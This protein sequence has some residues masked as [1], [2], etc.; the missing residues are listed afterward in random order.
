M[1]PEAAP[2]KRDKQNP[3][4]ENDSAFSVFTAPAMVLTGQ[5]GTVV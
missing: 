3:I 4:L 2:R 1:F 5:I